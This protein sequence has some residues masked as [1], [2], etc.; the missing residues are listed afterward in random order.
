MNVAKTIFSQLM[1]FLSQ[2]QFRLCVQRYNGNYKIKRFSCW[3]QFLCMAFAQ[4]TYRESLRDIQACLRASQKRLY[5]LSIRG[6]V[7][8]NTLSNANQSR[9]WRIY[10]DFAQIF[11]KGMKL[12]IGKR[13][14]KGILCGKEK[15]T[16][17]FIRSISSLGTSTWR[18][19]MDTEEIV[20]ARIVLKADDWEHAVRFYV[21]LLGRPADSTPDFGVAIWRIVSVCE[22]CVSGNAQ[23]AAK[24]ELVVR[25]VKRIHTRM[26]AELDFEPEGRESWPFTSTRFYQDPWGNEVFL[27]SVEE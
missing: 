2:Y 4:L 8:R 18:Y 17:H 16:P 6:R 15:I 19:A 26:K 21:V 11:R 23:K 3:D 24:F 5:H 7:S 14:S 13:T 27:R 25:D 20:G 1:E 10:A 9:D 12:W 22:L